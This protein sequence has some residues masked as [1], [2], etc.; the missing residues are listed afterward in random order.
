[1]LTSMCVS[2]HF[3]RAVLTL[4]GGRGYACVVI[5]VGASSAHE[6]VNQTV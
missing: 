2:A 3:A 6:K 4:I 1:M 5:F